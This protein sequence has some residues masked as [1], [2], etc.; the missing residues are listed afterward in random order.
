M[1]LG[2]HRQTRSYPA[3]GKF[4]RGV[5]RLLPVVAAVVLGCAVL[6]C[7]GSRPGRMLQTGQQRQ[8]SLDDAVKTIIY[9][10][11]QAAKQSA[12]VLFSC[13]PPVTL[14]NG[15]Q[16]DRTDGRWSQNFTV[17]TSRLATVD[18]LLTEARN[19][20]NIFGYF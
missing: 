18:W 9:Q 3:A 6:V 2:E 10:S 19:I 4:E 15:N 13:L 14:L 5:A 20:S 11:Q 16:N 8:I 12:G 17:G 7:W 1:R